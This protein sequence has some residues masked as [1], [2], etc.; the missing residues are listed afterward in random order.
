MK[1]ISFA[2]TIAQVRDETK[3][4][5]RRLGWQQ[6]KPGDLLL[7]VEK[8]M[9]LKKGEKITPIRNPIRVTNVRV[10]PLQRMLDDLRDGECECILE[11]FPDL[12][13]A[14]FVHMFC[15]AYRCT[16]STTITRI[17]FSYT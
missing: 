5:T 1:N 16:P 11:G 13:P 17:Q 9:G 4:V 7:P 3:S 6:L 10:E 8:C 14:Q 12:S 15:R 2:M